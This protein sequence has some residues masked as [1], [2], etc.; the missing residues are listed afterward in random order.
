MRRLFLTAVL[1][2]VSGPAFADVIGTWKTPRGS[3]VEI[4]RC[5]P[6]VCGKA[7]APPP[8]VT[9]PTTTDSKNKDVTL[10]NRSLMGLTIM[11]GFAGG[12]SVWSGGKIYNPDD[13][14]TYSGTLTLVG[15]QT[16]KLKGCVVAPLCQTQTWTRAK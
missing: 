1:M 13:G 5:G 9:P 15:D 4:Y 6:A 3:K 10:R 16:L 2:L 8:G 14:N 11:T 7:L 12:P